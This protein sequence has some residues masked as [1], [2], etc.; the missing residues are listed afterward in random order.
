MD[1]HAQRQKAADFLKLHQGPRILVLPNAWDAASARI[2]EQ[3]GFRAIGTTSAGVAYSLGYPDRQKIRREEMLETVTR[4]AR[5]VSVPVTADMEAGYAATPE[6]VA[7]TARAVIAAGAVGMNFEDG[8]DDPAN[9]L[10][11]ISLQVEKIRAIRE[12][13]SAAGVPLVLNARADVY[14]AAVGKPEERFKLAIRRVTAY[15]EA[16]ADCLFVPGV[17]DPE[18]IA[19][20]VQEAPGPVNILATAGTPPVQELEALGVARVSVGSG[21]MRAVLSLVRRIAAELHDAGSYAAFTQDTIPYAEANR[22]FSTSSRQG[23]E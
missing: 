4:I 18:V 1:I 14:L 15:R 6:E 8:T 22:L 10:A 5:S 7:N 23:T 13:A 12:A 11:E 21:P 2:F 17:S 3:A 19:G 16:G 20:L 9:P